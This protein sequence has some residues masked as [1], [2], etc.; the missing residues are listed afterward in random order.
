MNTSA[1]IFPLLLVVAYY[2]IVILYVLCIQR[3]LS[4]PRMT[5][6]FIITDQQGWLTVLAQL[7]LSVAI[8]YWIGQLGVIV[9]VCTAFVLSLAIFVIMEVYRLVSLR[10]VILQ[11]I[12]MSIPAFMLSPLGVIFAGIILAFSIDSKE[13]PT[14]IRRYKRYIAHLKHRY[15][16]KFGKYFALEDKYIAD[17]SLSI[18]LVEV[19]C[20]PW[21]FRVLEWIVKKTVYRSQP[22][23]TGIMQVM[24]P[25]LLS[26]GQSVVLGIAHVKKLNIHCKQQGLR[27]E[28]ERAHMIAAKYNGDSWYGD[29]LSPIYYFVRNGTFSDDN[30]PTS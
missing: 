17:V 30:P 22:M 7:G 3:H 25:T 20:R 24:S 14:Y 16:A 28:Y 10:S 18:L 13:S 11:V 9:I 6:K 21:I 27:D 5:E 23:S 29:Y 19:L 8:S 2:A 15:E 1:F 12:G 4:V 26:D